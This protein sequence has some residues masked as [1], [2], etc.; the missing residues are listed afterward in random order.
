[1]FSQRALYT[2]SGVSESLRPPPRAAAFFTVRRCSL[3]HVFTIELPKPPYMNPVDI[4][5]YRPV[6]P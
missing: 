6:P 5:F 3:P 2:V 1:M 4:F